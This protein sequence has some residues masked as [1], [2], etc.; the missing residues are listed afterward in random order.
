MQFKRDIEFLFELG[1]LRNMDRGW[2]QHLGVECANDLEHTMRVLWLALILARRHGGCDESLVMKM[3]L[4]HDLCE[5]RVSDHSYIQKVYVHADEERALKDTL[6]DTSLEDF[7]LIQDQ[8]EQRECIEAKIV[9]DADNL[10]VELEIKELIERG[11]QLPK[12]WA[13]FRQMVHDEKLHTQVAKDFWQ[14]VQDAD[15][16]DWHLSANK[17]VKMPETGK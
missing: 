3:A 16:A 6:K 12:R 7:E 1:S 15:P 8:Y 10:D 11:H 4:T 14:E 17:W 2:K 13:V 9:K 5:T